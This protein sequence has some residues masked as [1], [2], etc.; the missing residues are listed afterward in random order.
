MQA[1]GVS[2]HQLVTAISQAMSCLYVGNKKTP[3]SNTNSG[4]KFMGTPRPPKPSAGVDGLLD[5]NL[6]CWY[7]KDTRHKLD[8][9]KWLQNKLAHECTAMQSVATEESLNT[10][11]H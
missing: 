7:C 1:M 4:N 8:N 10:K 5:N 11:H 3:P 2:L 6:M 9:C